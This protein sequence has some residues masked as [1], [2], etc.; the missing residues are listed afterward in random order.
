MNSPVHYHLTDMGLARLLAL[1]P[2][3]PFLLVTNADNSYS[4]RFASVVLRFLQGEGEGEGQYDVALVDMVHRG[5]VGTMTMSLTITM[6]MSTCML[7]CAVL[8][9]FTLLLF[10]LLMSVVVVILQAFHVRPELGHMDLGCAVIRTSV[11]LSPVPAP[12]T[13]PA[14][15]LAA[16]SPLPLPLSLD[17]IMTFAQSLP[18]PAAPEHWHDAGNLQE[19]REGEREGGCSCATRSFCLLLSLR[20]FSHH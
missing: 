16:D 8:E 1:A 11:L 20:G 7:L 14:H 2:Q 4:P 12:D 13:P 17:R 19:G 6:T 3:L 9:M 15:A 10:T 18:A 5:Q